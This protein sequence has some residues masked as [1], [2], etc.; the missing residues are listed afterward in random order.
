[1]RLLWVMLH[2]CA[3]SLLAY[4]PSTHKCTHAHTHYHTLPHTHTHSHLEKTTETAAT[5][6]CIGAEISLSHTHTKQSR[7]TAYFN[8]SGRTGV[9]CSGRSCI[10]SVVLDQ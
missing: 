6:I 10:C 1:M 4:G 3:L 5:V 2:V 9:L 8:F 7:E